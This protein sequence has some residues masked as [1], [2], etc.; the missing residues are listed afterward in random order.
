MCSRTTCRK[1]GKPS[2]S[3]CG[4]HI[5]I[6]LQGVAKKDRCQG[7]AN[8][9]KGPGFLIK[10]FLKNSKYVEFPSLNFRDGASGEEVTFSRNW[11]GTVFILIYPLVSSPSIC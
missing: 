6:A 10:L 3:G 9:P 4:Q 11:W 1:C 8:D 2:W 5:E 7:H